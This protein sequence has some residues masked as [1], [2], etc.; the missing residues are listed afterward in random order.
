MAMAFPWDNDFAFVLAT[1]SS[2]WG[3]QNLARIIQLNPNR[4]LYY[5]HL[6]DLI[7]SAF[8][9]EYLR[10]WAIHYGALAGQNYSNITTYIGQRAT[11]V[12]GAIPKSLPFEITTNAGLDTS[13]AAASIVIEG[14]AWFDV[15]HIL[16]EDDD[17]PLEITWPTVTK[18]QTTIP[19]APGFNNL[20][21][22]AFDKHGDLIASDRIGVT[23]TLAA[24]PPAITSVA[25]ASGAPGDVVTVSGTGFQPGSQALFGGVPS[26]KS[27]FDPG[28][29][30]L[31]AA[32]VPAVAPGLVALTVKNADGRASGPKDFTVVEASRLFIRGD[33]DLSGSVELADVIKLLF[34]LYAGTTIQ[35]DDAADATNNG[36]LDV[37]DAIFLLNH[38]YRG[39]AAP[40]APYPEPGEDSGAADRLECARGL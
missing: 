20:S 27:T 26:P 32:E 5:C 14:N 38:L 8:N 7:D 24:P 4:R 6:L 39:G 28:K 29:P 31:L 17:A 15:R 2:L 9:A 35:C 23:N 16:L 11:F 1:N 3:D 22:L 34:H 25:P 30:G 13:V 19:L 12:K 18:W 36:F 33:V 37:A 21:F 40:Q 10:P